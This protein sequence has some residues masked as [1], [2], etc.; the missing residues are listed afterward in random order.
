MNS[1]D[2]RAEAVEAARQAR[3]DRF[4]DAR[5]KA[6]RR[7]RRRNIQDVVVSILLV[8]LFIAINAGLLYGAVRIVRLA[9]G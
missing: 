2:R 5:R 3:L 7:Q 9:W 8:A 4:A 6:T 1:A